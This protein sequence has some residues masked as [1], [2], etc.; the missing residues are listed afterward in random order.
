MNQWVREALNHADMSQQALSDALTRSKHLGTYDRSMVQKMTVGRRVSLQEA[1]QIS[2][3]TG[4]PLPDTVSEQEFS[5]MFQRLNPENQ[6]AIQT[7][8]SN[9]LRTQQGDEEG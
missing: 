2:Q 3:I 4:Y 6:Q 7:I 5:G 8:M 9:L 1:E